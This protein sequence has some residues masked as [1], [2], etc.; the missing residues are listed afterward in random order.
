MKFS[1]LLRTA[2]NDS[3]RNRGRLF[4]FISSIILGITALVAINSFNYNLVKDID[5]QA[6]TIS[7]ADITFSSKNE[8]S[9]DVRLL[10]DSL[11]AEPAEQHELFSMA[12]LPQVDASQFIRV[13]ALKGNFPFYGKMKSEPENA[14]RSFQTN[15]TALV[16]HNL[17][18]EHNLKTGDSINIGER[19]FI[20]EG[21]LLSDFGGSGV[22]STFAPSVYIPLDELKSTNLVQEG[23]LIE[24]KYYL[25]TVDGFDADAWKKQ[26]KATFQDDNVRV[27]TLKDQKRNLKD[28]F[29]FLNNFL[30]LVAL[31]SLILGCIGVASS[32]LIYIRSKI[33][34]IAVFRCLGMHGND[35]FL[36][37]FIQIF[38]LGFIGVLIGAFLGS[39]I[40]I[41]LPIVL[42]D[43][44][45]Y[46]VNLTVSYRA[47]FEGVGIGL[48]MTMLFAI[49]PLMGTRLVSPLRVLR[50]DD[51]Q[52]TKDPLR[53]IVIAIAL[54]FLFASLWVLTND[55]ML[56][57]FFLLGLL[58]IFACLFSVASLL[59]WVVRKYVPHSWS[60]VFRQG[61]SNLYRP[62]NQTRTLVVSIGL[63]TTIL[64]IL[65]IVQSL[66][67][68]NVRMMD[69]GNQ[70]NMI[71]FGIEKEQTD[72]LH[73][74]TKSMGMPVIQDVPIV[75]M[76]LDEWKGR[77]KSEWLADTT[78]QL[79]R[80]TVNREAR[81]TYR[82]YLEDD[83]SLTAGEFKGAYDGSDSIFIS[84]YEDYAA[85]LGVELGDELIWNVQG[86]RIK[87]YVS[88]FRKIQFN[89]MNTRF[90]I[91]FPT[92]V[93][94]KAPQFK[95]LVTKSPDNET[96]RTFR[97]EATKAFPNISVVDLSSILT[98]LNDIISKIS[99][100]IQ[101]MAGFSVLT[102]LV[103]LISSLLLSKFQRIKE[104]VLLR[105]LGASRKQLI[106]INASEYIFLGLIAAI[107]GVILAIGCGFLL[108]RFIFELPGFA[109]QW[110]QVLF[111]CLGVTGLTV[112][113]G[114]WNTRDLINESPLKV[115]RDSV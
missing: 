24:Y 95:V 4:I 20:I 108:S 102:G 51:S 3:K 85:G 25:K 7:G 100:I 60:Y 87:T 59:M 78:V 73:A 23:S 56:S 42:K 63:G 40:Q 1:L 45:P 32:V 43:I 76:R 90:F 92:G 109:V 13:K 38:I 36:I 15:K 61:V 88:S 30:N 96:M 79:E 21:A 18:K 112:A 110:S 64:T 46:E 39:A 75:T 115:L 16:D 68:N 66:L 33:N 113:I 71:V 81:V 84:L 27:Q 8:F 22:G 53:N 72:S 47:V 57:S 34:S 41:L 98:T 37:F 11:Q 17:L 80:W 55:I 114:L 6:K 89:S 69:A 106:L 94:E 104:T 26:H 111:I 44:L 91:L 86:T 10:I 50:Q 35:A 70:P 2:I 103:V 105:T 54:L 93:L 58:I 48:V 28:A 97:T 12:Y 62:N 67:L 52:K 29:Q 31:V 19:S 101:F 82:D 107:T 83:E 99:Y 14:Y 9:Q 49:I 77:S 5:S 74:L 65:V